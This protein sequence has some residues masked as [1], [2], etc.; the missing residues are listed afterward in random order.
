MEVSVLQEHM[1]DGDFPDSAG[2]KGAVHKMWLDW[3]Y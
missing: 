2:P 3:L 1:L